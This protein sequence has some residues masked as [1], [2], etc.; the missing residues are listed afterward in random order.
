MGWKKATF[1][2]TDTNMFLNKSHKT[3][4]QKDPRR[5]SQIFN[6]NVVYN[7]LFLFLFGHIC[8]NLKLSKAT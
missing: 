5:A 4:L 1:L 7:V 3:F 6:N 2:W 8:R